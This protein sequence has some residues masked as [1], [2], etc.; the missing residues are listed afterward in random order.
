MGTIFRH[1][2]AKSRGAII[3]WGL[4]LFLL[5]LLLVPIFD[6]IAE[7]KETLEQLMQVY[8][9][10]I[11]EF[12]GGLS[13]FSTPE[14]FLSIEYFSFM[15][16]ILGI[17]AIQAGSS[18]LA[19][20]EESGTLDLTMAHPLSRTGLL[21][22]RVSALL[23]T[24][25]VILTIGWLGIALL[26]SSSDAFN[27]SWGEL[28]LPFLSLLAIL[29]LFASLALFLSLILPSRRAASM[30]S[31]LV[32]VGGFFIDGLSGINTDLEPLSRYLPLKY[33]QG[34]DAFN[35][36]N[37]TWMAGLLGASVIFGLLAWWRF[38]RRD[39]RVAGEGSLPLVNR[40]RSLRKRNRRA[41]AS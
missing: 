15:P 11:F 41:G 12:F 16:I 8:P 13:D 4:G 1:A 19:S 28:A 20:D 30:V 3:G 40:L 34:G 37:W 14:G 5:G 31:G 24:L 21:L 2:L 7:E 25:I 6:V 32:L 22:G 39:I 27:L 35:G 26:G 38:E 33:Y 17:Y 29:V 23:V 9:A 36:L 18:L 10:E